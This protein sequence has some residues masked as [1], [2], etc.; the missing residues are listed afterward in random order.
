[1]L[2]LATFVA[3]YTNGDSSEMPKSTS[4]VFAP[5]FCGCNCKK[6]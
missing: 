1:M 3:L 5:N 4:G 2:I 6:Y